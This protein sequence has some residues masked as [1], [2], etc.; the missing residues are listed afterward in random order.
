MLR[1][2]R[3]WLG[4][5]ISVVFIALA[6]RGQDLGR[7]REALGAV[8]YRLLPLA[9]VLYF[10]GVL[11]R[12]LRWRYLLAPVRR[13][14]VRNLYPIV[15]IGYMAN[16][17]LPWRI[18]EVVRSY[19]L[20]EREGIP[21]SASL[22][23]IAVERIFDGLTMLAFL[24][25][26]SLVI[27]LDDAIR[28][29]AI[30]VTIVFVLAIIAMIVLVASNQ[31]RARLLALATRPFPPAIGTRLTALV[32][33]FV[34]GLHILR[35][36]KDLILVASCSVLAWGLE[37][38]MYLV[39]ARGFTVPAGAGQQPQSLADVLGIAG[40]LMTTAVAN[41]ATLIP[42]TPGY[43]GVFESGVVLVVN[44]ILGVER[45]V[46]LS[47]A[48]VVHAALYFPITLWGLYYWARAHISLNAVR[49]DASREPERANG[50]TGEGA[51]SRSG[52]AAR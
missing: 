7:V 35:S 27:P 23:T 42:S 16:N 49:S 18:G 36:F 45:E 24:F 5:L 46:A 38:S 4:L 41:L 19:V 22:A 17:V 39:I 25:L 15:V 28:L 40:A 33:S 9:L 34:S 47:Y 50:R 20:R 14:Q 13:L 21:T 37:S 52:D 30:A 31:L 29:R 32:E 26:A 11:V 43:I 6:I 10:G 8:D 1:N 3:L 51:R 2:W 48:I 12:T 44:G